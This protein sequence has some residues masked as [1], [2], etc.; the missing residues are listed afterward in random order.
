MPPTRRLSALRFR[1]LVWR[2]AAAAVVVL[3]LLAGV[4]DRVTAHEVEHA[5]ASAFQSAT[6][7]AS[8]PS[9][10]ITGFPVLTQVVSGRL[11]HVEMTADE[12]PAS[13]DRP[14]PVTTL[15]LDLYGLRAYG[16][17]HSARADSARAA[18][19]ISYADL[20]NALGVPVAEDSQAGRVAATASVPL[21]GQ[22]GVS[23]RIVPMSGNAI[24]FKDQR[25]EGNLPPGAASAITKALAQPLHLQ[26]VPKGLTLTGISA[27]ST[28]LHAEFTGRDV[29]FTTS[30]K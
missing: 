18:A 24:A 8:A 13:G 4:A 23:A 30:S 19:F 12:I 2:Y 16:Q 26:G 9:V 29:V 14:L 17:A 27:D 28:G 10:R 15:Q 21:I 6:G 1:P 5:T 7:S 3:T 11:D 25:T 20:T 22:V